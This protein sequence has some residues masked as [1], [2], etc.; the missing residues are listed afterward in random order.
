MKA[1]SV[2]DDVFTAASVLALT[3]EDLLRRALARY[4][5]EEQAACEQRLGRIFLEEHGLRRKYGTALAELSER[6]E[7]LEKRENFEELA[8]G[9]VPVLE[10]VSDTRRWEHLLEGMVQEEERLRQ[11]QILARISK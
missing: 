3:P 7:I 11:L 1:V 6:L 8:V 5:E 9:N 4:A 10:A 2:S